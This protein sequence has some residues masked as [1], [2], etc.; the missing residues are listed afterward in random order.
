M[1][2]RLSCNKINVLQRSFQNLNMKIKLQ[3]VFN[4]HPKLISFWGGFTSR[5]HC[6]HLKMKPGKFPY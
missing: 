3:N 4:C 5:T 1:R 6:T 2:E